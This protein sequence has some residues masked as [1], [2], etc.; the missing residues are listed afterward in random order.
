MPYLSLCHGLK[1][2]CQRVYL[3]AR[4]YFMN[5]ASSYVQ[6]AAQKIDFEWLSE[7]RLLYASEAEQPAI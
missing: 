3:S 4:Y 2:L 1:N 6:I 5:D 7:T